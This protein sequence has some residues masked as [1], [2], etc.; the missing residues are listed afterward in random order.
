MCLLCELASMMIMILCRKMGEMSGID[1]LSPLPKIQTE[2]IQ[3][4][5]MVGSVSEILEQEHRSVCKGRP[6]RLAGHQCCCHLQLVC[7]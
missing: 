7:V 6:T 5:A 4:S 1:V 3:L 2:L